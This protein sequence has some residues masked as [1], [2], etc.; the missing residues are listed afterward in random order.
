MIC[1]NYLFENFKKTIYYLYKKNSS[2]LNLIE[3]HINIIK[4]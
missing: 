3:I 4:E 2:I 1:I